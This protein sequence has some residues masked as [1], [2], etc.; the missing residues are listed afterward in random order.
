ML[1]QNSR[2][3]PKL[4]IKGFNSAILRLIEGKFIVETLNDH[5][6]TANANLKLRYSLMFV[7]FTKG[8]YSTTFKN[9]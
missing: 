9:T 7:H 2:W 8:Y 1:I 4:I 6:L 3:S 5:V